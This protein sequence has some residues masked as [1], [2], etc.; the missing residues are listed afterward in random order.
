VPADLIVLQ[1]NHFEC[2]TTGEPFT[3]KNTRQVFLISH[4]R[5]DGS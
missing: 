4:G 2:P 5:S 1:S 3:H